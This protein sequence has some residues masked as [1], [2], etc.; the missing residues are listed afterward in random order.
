[1]ELA[2]N[3]AYRQLDAIISPN[4][5]DTMRCIPLMLDYA[6]PHPPVIG[7]ALPDNRKIEAGINYTA[8]EYRKIATE[9]LKVGGKPISDEALAKSIKVYN[10]HRQTMMDF[11]D[12]ANNHLDIIT[13]YMR[14]MVIKSSFFMPKEKHTLWVKELIAELNTMPVHEWQGSKVF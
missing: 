4:T 10:I 14:H 5:C 12:V 2:L 6:L 1:M 9:L 3:G 7:L 11:F 8:D 13:P